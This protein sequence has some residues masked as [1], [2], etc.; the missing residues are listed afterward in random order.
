MS[1]FQELKRRNVIR[2]GIACAVTSWLVVQ[3]SDVVIDNIGAPDW[4]FKGI[5][6]LLG[7]GF[8]LVMVFAW[9]FE[10]TPE[11]IRKEKD[12]DRTQSITPHTGCRR[13][14]ELAGNL[15]Y[16][17]QFLRDFERA[18]EFIDVAEAIDPTSQHFY[19]QA[20]Q[21]QYAIEGDPA[22]AV[23][24]CAACTTNRAGRC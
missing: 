17:Y 20:G 24:S 14:V 8:P 15:S 7:I 13:P 11:G 1:F 12:V 19:T 3:V 18:R 5:L 10:L 21:V 16:T 22:A 9:A 6:L 23:R 4:L 2:A